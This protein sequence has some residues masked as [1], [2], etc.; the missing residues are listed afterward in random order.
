[1]EFLTLQRVVEGFNAPIN[2]EQAWAVCYQCGKILQI[3]KETSSIC[4]KLSGLRSVKIYKDG[5]VEGVDTE[6]Y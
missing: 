4:R 1:M 6:G 5:S 2:E 3:Q